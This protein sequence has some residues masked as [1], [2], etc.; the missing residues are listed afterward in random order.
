MCSVRNLLA[1]GF[2]RMGSFINYLLKPIKALLK[3]LSQVSG[4]FFLCCNKASG[5][6]YILFLLVLN[7]GKLQ[8]MT[9]IEKN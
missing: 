7:I 5:I 8:Y 6:Q 2:S 4:L 1:S 3:V 9:K